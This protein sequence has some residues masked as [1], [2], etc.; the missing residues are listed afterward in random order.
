MTIT[1]TPHLSAA[2]DLLVLNYNFEVMMLAILKQVS[3]L[4]MF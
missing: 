2:R 4:L 3:I 1:E